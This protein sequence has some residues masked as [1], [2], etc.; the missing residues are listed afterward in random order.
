[1]TT[2]KAWFDDRVYA[3]VKGGSAMWAKARLNPSCEYGFWF[4]L[5]YVQIAAKLLIPYRAHGGGLE[6]KALA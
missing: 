2:S 3:A 1:M 6:F 5:V 4:R